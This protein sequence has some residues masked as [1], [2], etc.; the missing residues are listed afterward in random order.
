MDK[1][2]LIEKIAKHFGVPDS[3]QKLFFEVFLRKCSQVLNQNEQVKIGEIGMIE[4]MEAQNEQ[5]ED[6]IV[7][8]TNEGEEFLFGIPEEERETNSIDSYFSISIGKPVIPLRGEGDSEFFIPHTGNEIKKM[9]GL[10][11]E[12]FIEDVRKPEPEVDESEL[13]LSD[14]I[15]RVDFSFKNWKSASY[16]D[17][18]SE[19]LEEEPT[20]EEEVAEQ[21]VDNSE[22]EIQDEFSEE[23]EQRIETI[24]FETNGGGEQEELEEIEKEILGESGDVEKELETEEEN[25]EPLKADTIEDESEKEF[26][27]PEKKETESSEDQITDKEYSQVQS[28]P[29]LIEEKKDEEIPDI[30]QKENIVEEDSQ[31]V[32]DAFKYAEEKSARIESYRKRSYTGFIFAIIILAVVGGVIYLSFYLPDT[33]SETSIQSANPREFAVTIE[34][35]YEIPV[36]YPYEKGMLGEAHNAIDE[37]IISLSDRKTVE[38]VSLND[39]IPEGIEIRNPLPTNRIKGYIYKYENMYAVQVSSW[40]S[41]SIAISETQKFLSAGLDAFIEKTELADKG[42]YYRVR[43]GGFSSLAEAEEFLK[44]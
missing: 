18:E 21:A 9:F 35:S 4:F 3:E 12:R 16:S 2:I 39:N 14:D 29:G 44:K 11:V 36:T 17:T 40:K 19:E 24:S 22:R 28:D 1:S 32:E 42:V 33:G 27:D 43:I 6:S 41:K 26:I 25:I 13:D 15:P 10:K 23:T 37:Y 30:A 34:R 5:D 8:F 31:A 38:T 7:I 20:V